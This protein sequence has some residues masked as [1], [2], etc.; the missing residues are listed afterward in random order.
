MKLPHASNGGTGRDKWQFTFVITDPEGKDAVDGLIY[1]PSKSMDDSSQELAVYVDSLF[2]YVAENFRTEV[3]YYDEALARPLKSKLEEVY[4]S[5]G[6]SMSEA[7]RREQKED[8]QNLLGSLKNQMQQAEINQPVASTDVEEVWYVLSTP[9]RGN[10][11]PSSQGAGK[12]LVG[13]TGAGKSST[14][15][16]VCEKTEPIIL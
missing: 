15:K 10:R 7:E 5:L 12:D 8:L 1:S 13:E 14:W 6:V 3:G 16:F 9:L 4:A 2:R 11:Y